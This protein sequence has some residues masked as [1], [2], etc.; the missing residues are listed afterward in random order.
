MIGDEDDGFII[1]T[2]D[3]GCLWQGGPEDAPMPREVIRAAVEIG[4][5]A[6]CFGAQRRRPLDAPDY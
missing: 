1:S 6:A 2:A 5:N 3:Y 4:V